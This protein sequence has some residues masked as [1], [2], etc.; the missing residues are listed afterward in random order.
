MDV[1]Y[2][3]RVKLFISAAVAPEQLYEHG[4]LAHEFV[5]TVSRLKEMQSSE[6]LA[7]QRRTVQNSTD[8]SS[9]VVGHPSDAGARRVA[10]VHTLGLSHP[11]VFLSTPQAAGT[12]V[13][14]CPA[15]TTPPLAKSHLRS[16]TR[17]TC[18]IL[19]TIRAADAIRAYQVAN[20]PYL[21]RIQGR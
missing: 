2:D 7:M 12:V 3:R 17:V 21:L 16:V 1:L 5:R 15:N 6:Y 14:S 20:A 10:L 18:P 11:Q 9:A 19:S 8:L 4:P 13:Q